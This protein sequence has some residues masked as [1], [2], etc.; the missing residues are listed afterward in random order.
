METHIR[1]RDNIDGRRWRGN[2]IRDMKKD[3]FIGSMWNRAYA[4]F[5]FAK[6]TI[7]PKGVVIGPSIGA[8]RFAIAEY[9]FRWEAV[10]RVEVRTPIYGAQGL[11]FNL[12]ASA[13]KQGGAGW[14]REAM[15][16]S[17]GLV[18]KAQLNRALAVIPESLLERGARSH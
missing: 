2:T 10:E 15:R 1:G 6:M 9:A 18:T 7:T 11:R 5:P 12:S 17:F 14:P 8:L 4:T 16:L 13:R 3:T